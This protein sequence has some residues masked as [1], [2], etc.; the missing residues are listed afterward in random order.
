MKADKTIILFCRHHKHVIYFIPLLP[1][2]AISLSLYQC[3]VCIV[4]G[5]K[6]GLEMIKKA[7]ILAVIIVVFGLL[8]VSLRAELAALTP[9]SSSVVEGGIEYYIQTDKA[10][11]NLGE[12]VEILYRV[13]NLTDNPVSIGEKSLFSPDYDVIITDDGDTKVWQYI[14]T[15]PPPPTPPE[16]TMFHLE[17][18]E[19]KDYQTTWDLTNDNGTSDRTDDLPVDPGMYNV[20][21]ELNLYFWEEIVPVSVSVETIPE[22]ATFLLL[23]LGGLAVFLCG[24]GRRTDKNR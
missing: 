5:D 8:T 14:L 17:P 1:S 19:S 23:G 12:N 15:L 9:N 24:R 13:T 2:K 6:G 7:G 3:A 11:Y 20:T 4:R 10:V 22:P 18:Y 16:T 21:G